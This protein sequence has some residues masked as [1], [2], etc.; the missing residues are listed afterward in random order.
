MPGWLAIKKRVADIKEF[1]INIK[2]FNKN[3]FSD[4]ISLNLNFE[5]ISN[6]SLVSK[7]SD[8][9]IL[10]YQNDELIDLI[11]LDSKIDY[12]TN[13]NIIFYKNWQKSFYLES[14]DDD[15]LSVLTMEFAPILFTDN[16]HFIV[17]DSLVK[18]ITLNFDTVA[19]IND[20]SIAKNLWQYYINKNDNKLQITFDSSNNNDNLVPFANEL[21]CYY[22]I[23]SVLSEDGIQATCDN[24]KS[25]YTKREFNDFSVSG[26]NR[27]TLDTQIFDQN[28]WTEEIVG[29]HYLY[30]ESMY[31]MTIWLEAGEEGHIND[32]FEKVSKLVLASELFNDRP[33]KNYSEI[34]FDDWY[35]SYQN[36]LENKYKGTID[37][38]FSDQS[39]VGDVITSESYDVWRSGNNYCQQ[40]DRLVPI[41]N[42]AKLKNQ[43]SISCT[44][45]QTYNGTYKVGDLFL[46]GPMWMGIDPKQLYFTL[47]K[48]N[49]LLDTGYLV[50]ED[51]YSFNIPDKH[52]NLNLEYTLQKQYMLQKL[53]DQLTVWDYDIRNM[54]YD[55][56]YVSSGNIDYS[57]FYRL[58][59]G[60]N[61]TKNNECS[62]E[63]KFREPYGRDP[64]ET[65]SWKQ[66]GSSDTGYNNK[67]TN[68]LY[69]LK[70]PYDFIMCY[71]DNT[72]YFNQSASMQDN[73]DFTLQGNTNWFKM[74]CDE[75]SSTSPAT[76]TRIF[77]VFVNRIGVFWIPIE[78][79]GGTTL[80]NVMEE[81]TSKIQYLT[82]HP[83]TET[84]GYFY[85]CSL[86]S[87]KSINNGSHNI[88]THIMYHPSQ[89][90]FKSCNLLRNNEL[91]EFNQWLLSSGSI[92]NLN[93]G[94]NFLVKNDISQL[95]LDLVC[96]ID[97]TTHAKDSDLINS[98]L[99]NFKNN[100]IT[101]LN[102]LI[103][104]QYSN[105]D[106]NKWIFR[107]EDSDCDKFVS[108]YQEFQKFLP[109]LN[110]TMDATD[111]NRVN[112]KGFDDQ[113]GYPVSIGIY[114]GCA[115]K[116]NSIWIGGEDE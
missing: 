101:T 92:Y 8:L 61:A 1:N 44:E 20:I 24:N 11:K 6:D 76:K 33:E 85:K 62:F 30:P 89:W 115:P 4:K 102:T 53:S 98:K 25:D 69:Y 26:I 100:D 47:Y 91:A 32:K 17:F 99:S 78:P 16:D 10:I 60:L 73:S 96:S 84:N 82:G 19:D 38:S 57:A 3:Q 58:Y 12:Y 112:Y 114:A 52:F 51:I 93:T 109:Y 48:N 81:F 28:H 43:V 55:D 94:N 37:L 59:F 83:E 18:N 104:A 41:E 29:H 79:T 67:I 107:Q 31:I 75:S 14:D 95:D 39:S 105:Y 56:R 77:I 42:T 45:N 66:S 35:N 7:P 74:K 72:L 113:T 15:P 23:Q 87:E 71:V 9:G 49:V 13:G 80:I 34:F 65:F 50:P 40:F 86:E 27:L 111:Y 46:W 106:D 68:W 21:R 63:V 90:L 97:F 64:I 88:T 70:V 103:Q 54:N 5:I 2:D 108:N 22:S 110:S 116:S 36:F